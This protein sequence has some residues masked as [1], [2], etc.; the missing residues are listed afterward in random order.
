MAAVF[1]SV[2]IAGNL[3]CGDTA[4]DISTQKSSARNVLMILKLIP[5]PENSMKK[6][7]EKYPTDTPLV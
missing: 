5:I 2:L 4:A 3:I 7:M 6:Q 1:I